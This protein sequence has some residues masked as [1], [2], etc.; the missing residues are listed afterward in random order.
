VEEGSLYAIGQK[1]LD[2]A[3]GAIKTRSD[4]AIKDSGE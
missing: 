2:A 4:Q 3:M 1:S